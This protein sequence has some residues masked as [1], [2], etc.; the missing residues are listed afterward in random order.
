MKWLSRSNVQQDNQADQVGNG[1]GFNE[2]KRPE[3]L[4]SQ[5]QVG[6][7]YGS[8]FNAIKASVN[9]PLRLDENKNAQNILYPIQTS[10]PRNHSLA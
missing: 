4:L 5:H 2:Q 8:S 3:H 1:D 9:S 6:N 7:G 10:W